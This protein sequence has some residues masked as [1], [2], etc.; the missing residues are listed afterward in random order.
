MKER[1]IFLV[2]MIA[3]IIFAAHGTIWAEDKELVGETR[4]APSAE[5]RIPPSWGPGA[6]SFSCDMKSRTCTCIGSYNCQ[7]LENSGRCSGPV[8]RHMDANTQIV[9]GSCYTGG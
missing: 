3:W 5:G 6:E 4:P 1:V 9:A 2:A 7:I 8:S